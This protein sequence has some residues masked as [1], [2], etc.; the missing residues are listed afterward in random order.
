MLV[1]C[2]SEQLQIQ[3]AGKKLEVVKK[4]QGET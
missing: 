3:S 1:K 2:F 4:S